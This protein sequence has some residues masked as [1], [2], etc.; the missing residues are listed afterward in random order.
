M[1]QTTLRIQREK[2][3]LFGSGSFGI[4]LKLG[5]RQLGSCLRAGQWSGLSALIFFVTSVPGLR[6]GLV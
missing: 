4:L 1:I 6:P 2:G 5:V 3:S